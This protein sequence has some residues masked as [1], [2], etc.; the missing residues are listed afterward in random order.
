VPGAL[1]VGGAA[2][3]AGYLGRPDLT[4]ATF[5]PDPFDPSG[6][7]RVVRTGDRGRWLNDGAIELLGR[8]DRLVKIRGF[9]VEPGEIEAALSR[10]PALRESAVVARADGRA[11]AR[12][13]AYIES[14]TSPPPTPNELRAFLRGSLPEFMLP[15]Q[16]VTLEEMPRTPTG[17]L[18]RRA[19]PAD[20]ARPERTTAHVAPRTPTE[21]ALA[22]IWERLLDVRPIGVDDNFFDLGGQSLLVVRTMTATRDALGVDL[23]ART[24]FETPTI[25]ELAARI[26]ATGDVAAPADDA[27]PETSITP[28]NPG[29]GGGIFLV[30]GGAGEAFNLFPFAKLLRRAAP[31][32]PAWGFV[33]RE[34][35]DGSG[36]AHDWVRGIAAHYV[37]E[38]RAQQPNGPYIIIGACAGGNIAFDMAQQLHAAGAEV[39]RLILMDVWHAG[40]RSIRRAGNVPLFEEK[41]PDAL[42]LQQRLAH[43]RPGNAVGSDEAAAVDAGT[44]RADSRETMERR[45][46][47]NR[48]VAEPYPGPITVLVNEAWHAENTTLGWHSVAAGGLDVIVMNGGHD[49]Y[50]TDHFAETVALLRDVFAS[51]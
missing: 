45:F 40:G 46:W 29:T 44:L 19:L 25:A 38:L 48:Y 16:F 37:R 47:L 50:L 35:F 15:A 3:A 21:A 7:S 11:D 9:R 42:R 30:P 10:H 14:R 17:K 36:E 1:V 22:S 43:R 27:G 26:D 23:P 51:L 13:V 5:V 12:L 2:A 32:R 41:R 20:P 39:A 6:T 28:L 8:A 49:T 33:G 4:A 18:D 31:D 24:L 34:R